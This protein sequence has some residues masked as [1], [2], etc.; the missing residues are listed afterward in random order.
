MWVL[1]GEGPNDVEITALVWSDGD[2]ALQ[3]CKEIFGG[4]PKFT[5]EKNGHQE[6]QWACRGDGFPEEVT[7]KMYTSYYGGCGECYSATLKYI[8]EGKPFCGFNLD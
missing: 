8:E 7:D 1:I 4:E 6:Y 2:V 3:A 5:R